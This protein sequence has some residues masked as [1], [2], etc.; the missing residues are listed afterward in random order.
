MKQRNASSGVQT[1]GSPR[2]LKLVLTSTGHPVSRLEPRQQPVK[3]RIR[4]R[5]DRLDTGGIVDMGYRG[6]VQARDVELVDAERR[7]FLGAHGAPPLPFT[8]A[9]SSM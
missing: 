5:A 9:T 6:N 7:L 4:L 8:S 1:I 3:T 2:T